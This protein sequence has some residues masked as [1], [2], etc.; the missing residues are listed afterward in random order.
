MV[1]K[2]QILVCPVC[3]QEHPQWVEE[4]SSCEACGSTRLS[5]IMGSVVCRACGHDQPT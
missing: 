3:Q 2:E 4:L 5:M 1:K